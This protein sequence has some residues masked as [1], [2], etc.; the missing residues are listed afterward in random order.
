MRSPWH[1]R[2]V[3]ALWPPEAVPEDVGPLIQ[4]NTMKDNILILKYHETHIQKNRD[5]FLMLKVDSLMD[6]EKMMM[7]S[8]M[9]TT[10]WSMSW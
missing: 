2:T 8:R 3:V 7:Q 4:I 1:S 5:S 6:Y 9:P 10:M